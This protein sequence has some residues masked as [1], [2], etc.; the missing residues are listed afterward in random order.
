MGIDDRMRMFNRLDLECLT[1]SCSETDPKVK[2][3]T[4]ESGDNVVILTML[5]MLVMVVMVLT[6]ELHGWPERFTGVVGCV[7]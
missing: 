6:D 4:Q 3:E 7:L 2:S 5:T 1:A